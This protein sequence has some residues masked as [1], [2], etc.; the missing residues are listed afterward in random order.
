MA[1]I[2][3]DA[4][5]AHSS[6]ATFVEFAADLLRF[7]AAPVVPVASTVAEMYGRRSLHCI[8]VCE[9][10]NSSPKD[11]VNKLWAV[12]LSD[13]YFDDSGGSLWKVAN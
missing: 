6:A 12:R 4:E 3:T 5:V 9:E 11:M 7:G 8:A 10:S 2:E 13:Y 1:Q